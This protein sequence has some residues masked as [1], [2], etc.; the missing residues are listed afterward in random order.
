MLQRQ[1]TAP[2][3]A[4]SSL[5]GG[6]GW[7]PGRQVPEA[8]PWVPDCSR[9]GWTPQGQYKPP[10][11]DSKGKA[12]RR[13]WGPKTISPEF[14]KVLTPACPGLPASQSS[15]SRPLGPCEVPGTLPQT[16]Q[17]QLLRFLQ[18]CL[19]SD[20]SLRSSLQSAWSSSRGQN[21]NCG[22][23]AERKCHPP[24]CKDRGET[25]E[26][27]CRDGKGPYCSHCMQREERVPKIDSVG[28]L[29]LRPSG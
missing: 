27:E 28:G 21:T 14:W 13:G 20:H 29:A 6:H 23:E 5:L 18:R 3:T 24:T 16:P 25:E 2:Q 10:A 15:C 7:A 4:S 9:Q 17:G 22:Y 12:Q 19:C 26:E 11:Q 8:C 1:H